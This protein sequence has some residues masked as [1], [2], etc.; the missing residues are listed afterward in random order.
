VILGKPVL[1]R[2]GKQKRL[3]VAAI[4]KT[5][6]HK[7]ILQKLPPTEAFFGRLTVSISD[8]LVSCRRISLVAGFL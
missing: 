6:V 1:Q 7:A 2:R 5:L 4:A 3:I 8:T